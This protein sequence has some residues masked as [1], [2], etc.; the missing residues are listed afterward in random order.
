MATTNA[1]DVELRLPGQDALDHQVIRKGPDGWELMGS[2]CPKCHTHFFPPRELCANDLSTCEQVKLSHRGIIYAATR[3]WIG[4]VGFIPPYWAAF[5]DLPEQVRVF[6]ILDWKGTRQPRH[7][8]NV[9]LDVRL[10]RSEPDKV[11]GPIFYGP[12]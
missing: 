7:G 2:Q 10:A 3:V 8:D 4:P 11:I 5:I 9:E 12:V 6:T 1:K